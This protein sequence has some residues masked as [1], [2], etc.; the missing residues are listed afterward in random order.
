MT[1]A[2]RDKIWMLLPW[3]L[4]GSALTGWGFMASLAARDPGFSLEP[5]YYR[6]ASSWDQEQ[7]QRAE[8]ARLGWKLVAEKAGSRVQL[9]VDASDGRVSGASGEVEAFAIARASDVQKVELREVGPGR[10]AAPIRFTRPGLWELRATVRKGADKF[11]Q[12]LRVEI[13]AEGDS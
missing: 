6:K 9:V 10:Y 2:L 5:D 3:A 7:A 11:T 4:L 13:S 8:N 1:T 12:T